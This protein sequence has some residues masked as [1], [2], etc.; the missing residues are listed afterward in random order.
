MRQVGDL[1]RVFLKLKS[2]EL[3]SVLVSDLVVS[4]N[5]EFAAVFP[6]L[7]KLNKGE[8]GETRAKVGTEECSVLELFKELGSIIVVTVERMSVQP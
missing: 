8:F 7:E 2:E 3:D 4:R 6:I 5:T 1:P